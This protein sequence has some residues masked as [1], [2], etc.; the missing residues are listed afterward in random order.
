MLELEIT[1]GM[2]VHDIDKTTKA[3]KKFQD[4]GIR[5]AVDDFGTGFSSMNYLKQLPVNVLK[6]DRCF[7]KDINNSPNDASIATGM[8]HLAHSLKLEVIAEG[9]DS[10]EQFSLLKEKGID[11]IQGFLYSKALPGDEIETLISHQK[12]RWEKNFIQSI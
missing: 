12:S 7:I 5:I 10:I 11:K 2:L 4:M 8:I 9:V 1:E 3:L 6:I